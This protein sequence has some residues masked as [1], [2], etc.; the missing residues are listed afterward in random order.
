MVP[1]SQHRIAR[2]AVAGHIGGLRPVGKAAQS[3]HDVVCE[4]RRRVVRCVSPVR[5]RLLIKHKTLT[6]HRIVQVGRVEVARLIRLQDVGHARRCAVRIER[7]ERRR[8][9]EKDQLAVRGA[10]GHARVGQ[11]RGEHHLLGLRLF[12]FHLSSRTNMSISPL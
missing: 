12:A 6:L 11:H 2:V 4:K 1:L 7:P 8:R 3:Q 5:V 10:G 9:T